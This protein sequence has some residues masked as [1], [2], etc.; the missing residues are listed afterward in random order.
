MTEI[1][2][3][4]YL[5][6][7]GYACPLPFVFAGV[8]AVLGYLGVAKLLFQVLGSTFAVFPTIDTNKHQ[9]YED[10]GSSK[11]FTTKVSNIKQ[12]LLLQEE[13]CIV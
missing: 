2:D 11:G 1:F 4:V 6:F 12:F 10:F 5:D 7:A 9:W 3:I 8:R 13:R